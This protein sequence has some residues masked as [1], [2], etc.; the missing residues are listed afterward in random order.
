M[1]N[2]HLSDIDRVDKL[3]AMVITAF[4]WAY[5]V[6]IYVHEN[7]KQLKIKKHG[8]REKSLFKYGLGI[9][10]DI[11]LNPQKQH[12]IEIFHFLSCT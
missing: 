4:T 8:R 1:E 3:F 7:L 11:L 10:A 6:G 9:I 12:K 5:I 2:T